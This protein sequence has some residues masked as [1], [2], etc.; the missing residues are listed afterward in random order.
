MEVDSFVGIEVK[1]PGSDWRCAMP[2]A[3][4]LP[5]AT[6]VVPLPPFPYPFPLGQVPW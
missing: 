6:P 2:G 3:K 5:H 1:S 4:S